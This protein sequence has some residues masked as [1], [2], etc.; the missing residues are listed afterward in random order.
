MLDIISQFWNYPKKRSNESAEICLVCVVSTCSF[1][2]EFS[3]ALKCTEVCSKAF[4]PEAFSF[5]FL[6]LRLNYR[7]EVLQAGM[8]PSIKRVR[9]SPSPTLIT[10][11]S[12][13]QVLIGSSFCESSSCTEGRRPPPE[14]PLQLLLQV[15]GCCIKDVARGRLSATTPSQLSR[16]SP[17]RSS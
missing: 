13:G 3:S 9:F 12:R 1:H 17:P 11:Y 16:S 7:V 5:Y 4:S 10:L 15:C 6:S 14:L 2:S 8:E